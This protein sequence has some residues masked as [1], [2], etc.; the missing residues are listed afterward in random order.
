MTPVSFTPRPEA[1]VDQLRGIAHAASIAAEE[2]HDDDDRA[3]FLSVL[4]NLDWTAT[5]RRWRSAL[6]LLRH[7]DPIGDDPWPERCVACSLWRACRPRG[8]ARPASV[9]P[10]PAPRLPPSRVRRAPRRDRALREWQHRAAPAQRDRP[11]RPDAE[12]SPPRRRLQRPHPLRPDARVYRKPAQH[13]LDVRRRDRR[14]RLQAMAAE[15][16]VTVRD[17]RVR[18]GAPE[19]YAAFCSCGW[20]GAERRADNALRA[21]TRD[22]KRHQD[23]MRG[24]ASRRLQT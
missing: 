13:R 3:Y 15:H 6:D 19:I 10:A 2:Y 24:P 18:F 17:L 22:G 5:D 7:D 8:S 12:R 14:H 4:E 1:T 11:R 21:A 9:P 23:E 20:K 16:A